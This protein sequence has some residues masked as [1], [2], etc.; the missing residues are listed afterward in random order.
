MTVK[1]AK[2]ASLFSL[3][4]A[5]LNFASPAFAVSINLTE[6]LWNVFATDDR[7]NTW[8][9]TTL[10][11]T[12]QIDNGDNALVEGIF[13]WRSNAGEFG[14]EAFV[15]TLFSDL[16]LELT[17][18][19][20][21]QPSQGIVTAQYTAIVTNDGEQIIEGE[22][23]R[24]PG[25]SNVIPGSWSAIREI[26]PDPTEPIPNVPEPNNFFGLLALGGL[27]LVKKLHKQL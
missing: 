7:G 13:K 21:L 22:W 4:L 8:D 24:I 16:S 11:F 27:G 5:T 20:I 1:F 19:E 25:G 15:G 14:T 17:G 3:T 12:S 26:E 2:F 6:G 18:N 9:G 23:G 10:L